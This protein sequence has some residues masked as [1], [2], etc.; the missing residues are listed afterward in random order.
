MPASKSPR[1]QIREQSQ[2]PSL[3]K[4]GKPSGGADG[5]RMS[6][7]F[8]PPDSLE[9]LEAGEGVRF[10]PLPSFDAPSPRATD[11][12]E[13]II[14]IDD[15]G[16]VHA[17]EPTPEPT[18][19]AAPVAEAVAPPLAPST[20]VTASASS[21]EDVDR[22]WDWIRQDPDQG[23]E[24]LSARMATSVDLHTVIAVLQQGEAR[25]LS[26]IRSVYVADQHM[27]FAMLAPILTAENVAVVHIYLRPEARG[28]LAYLV[29]PLT[30]LASQLAPGVRLA[31]LSEDK[32]L[33][34]L[35]KLLAPLGFTEHTM[36]VR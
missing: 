13:E 4:F 33:A 15:E 19:A 24:F 29:A 2:T 30:E 34:A 27:G 3:R 26:I 28:H 5:R 17:L 1:N 18:T 6:L 14:K 16:V 35:R 22:L 31:V 25:G 36:F 10:R 9:E 20:L 21:R 11:V 7:T 12:P 23:A 32:G 8:V